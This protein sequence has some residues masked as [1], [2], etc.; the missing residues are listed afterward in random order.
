MAIIHG[1][2]KHALALAGLLAIATC[3]SVAPT[4]PA[5]ASSAH[6]STNGLPPPCVTGVALGGTQTC[7]FPCLSPSAGG[8][9]FGQGT[10]TITCGTYSCTLPVVGQQG[11]IISA[12]SGVTGTC[13]FTG[14][15]F[16][17]CSSP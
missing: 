11:C 3:G 4:H 17:E 15:G 8:H 13:K 9:G 16:A 1:N 12:S 10:F 5:A 6:A 2:L 7:S 14:T